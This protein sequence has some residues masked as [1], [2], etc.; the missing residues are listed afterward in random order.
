MATVDSL[1]YPNKSHRKKVRLPEHSELL[2]EFFGIMMGDG[3]INNNW[4]ANIS[5]N[6]IT[7]AAYA[8]R[9]VEM[10]ETLFKIRPSQFKR[11]E[12]NCIRIVISST[13]IV[14]FLVEHGLVRG[15]KLKNGLSIPSWILENPQYKAACLRGLMDTDGCLYTHKHS[16]AGQK[17]KNIGLCFSSYSTKLLYQVAII[18]NGTNGTSIYL[19]RADAVTKY[20]DVFGTS[21]ERISSV[22]EVWRR[23]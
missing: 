1:G 23:G 5:I 3:G 9:I 10:I 13:T 11:K 4:Q 21:N 18:F 15:N 17:Y 20:L 16:I 12:R 22:Y 6:S 19:Y 8:I 2:A 7:D 14:D